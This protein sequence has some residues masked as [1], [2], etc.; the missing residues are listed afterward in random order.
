MLGSSI[1]NQTHQIPHVLDVSKVSGPSVPGRAIIIANLIMPVRRGSAA[2]C[3]TESNLIVARS[4]CIAMMVHNKSNPKLM[5]THR[6]GLACL[7]N[8]HHDWL[9]WLD[10]D[11]CGIFAGLPML[12]PIA[13]DLKHDH[14]GALN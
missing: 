14:T 5:V 4:R 3:S 13:L 12:D 9:T 11:R 8:W 10:G 2:S 1:A 7:K 6:H